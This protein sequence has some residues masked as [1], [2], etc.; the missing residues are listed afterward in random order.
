M[1][2][3]SDCVGECCIC[4]CS[5]YCVAGHSED[6]YSLASKERIIKN[7][8]EGK[9]SSYKQLMIDTLK[10]VYGYEYCKEKTKP[11]EGE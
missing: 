8:D 5:G 4:E 9:F 11:V 7:L 1:K 2:F 10:K 6:N 3:F